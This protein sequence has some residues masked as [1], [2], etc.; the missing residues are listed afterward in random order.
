VN[1]DLY[2]DLGSPPVA[3]NRAGAQITLASDVVTEK[4]DWL[5]EGYIPF[6]KLTIIDGWPGRGKSTLTVDLVARAS[7]GNPMPLHPS[8]PSWAG[9]SEP[10]TSILLSAEDGLEDT[11]VPRLMA[12]GADLKHVVA[13][14]SMGNRSWELPGD[15][16]ALEALTEEFGARLIIIDPLMAFFGSKISANNDQDVRRALHPLK[17]FAARTGAAVV[18]VR[19]LRKDKGEGAPAMAQGGGSIGISGACRSCIIVA[20]DPHDPDGERR[21]MAVAKMNVGKPGPALAFHLQSAV[22]FDCAEIVWEGDSGH[23]AETVLASVD[24]T[25][26]E[27]VGIAGEILKH[28]LMDG[29]MAAEEVLPKIRP[30]GIADKHTARAKRMLGVE[31][32]TVGHKLMWRLP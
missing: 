25:E 2:Q 6:G 1:S 4:V 19:H 28:I 21:I 10:F 9:A 32:Y 16:G 13:L 30:N 8:S 3:R 20:D 18:L 7:T 26:L 17:D 15:L 31:Q 24:K 5:W 12:H 22:G 23:T 27:Q 29:P 11:I 14:D